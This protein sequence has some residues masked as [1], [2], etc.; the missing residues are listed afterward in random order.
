MFPKY[1]LHF[2]ADKEELKLWDCGNIQGSELSEKIPQDEPRYH[3]FNFNHDFE[4]E[5][6]WKV[7][8]IYSCPGYSVSSSNVSGGGGFSGISHIV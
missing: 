5:K 2:S 6:I 4:G 1:L 7:V 8:F 3:L